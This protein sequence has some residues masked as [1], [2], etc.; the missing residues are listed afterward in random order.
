MEQA[1]LG[2]EISQSSN[3]ACVTALGAGSDS[4][5]TKGFIAVIEIRAQ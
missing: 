1:I 5:G 2:I 4:L 3:V